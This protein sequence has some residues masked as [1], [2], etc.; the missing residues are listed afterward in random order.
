V[1]VC[2]CVCLCVCVF[3]H[4]Y[5]S[6]VCVPGGY[7]LCVYLLQISVYVHDILMNCLRVGEKG[8]GR[9]RS[10]ASERGTECH[11][12]VPIRPEYF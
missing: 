4:V 7:V 3:A 6:F 9:S 12:W 8:R 2:V 1:C 10:R 5:M 11:F